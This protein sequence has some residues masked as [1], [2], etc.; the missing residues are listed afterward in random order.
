MLYFIYFFKL[1]SAASWQLLPGQHKLYYLLSLA[2]HHKRIW[3]A[4]TK[5]I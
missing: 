4:V 2:H 3:K 5:F 1:P